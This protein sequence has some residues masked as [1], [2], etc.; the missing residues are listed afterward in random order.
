VLDGRADVAFGAH[1]SP[2]RFLT[3]EQQERLVSFHRFGRIPSHAILVANTLDSAT[4]AGVRDAF[5]ALNDSTNLPLLRAIYGVDGV[6]PATTEEHLGDFGRALEALPGMQ[7]TLL[8][9]TP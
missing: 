6:R 5:M 9:K 4:V 8:N 1:D 2:A 7:Q 3:P